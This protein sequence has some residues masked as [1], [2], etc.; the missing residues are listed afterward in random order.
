MELVTLKVFD[1]PIEAHIL[2]SKL[3]SENIESFVFDEHS[4][5]INML[6][7][8]AIGGVKL[9]IR[10]TDSEKAWSI[11]EEINNTKYTDDNENIIVCPSCGGND[12]FTNYKSSKGTKGLLSTLAS[13][14]FWVYPIYQKNVLKCKNCDTEIDM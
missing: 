13:F 2:R 3:E 4:V 1:S 11:L 5:G 6:Y 9:K 7:A 10:Q 14:L 8:Q 12:F